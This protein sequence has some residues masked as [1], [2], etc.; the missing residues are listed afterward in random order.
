[1]TTPTAP[2]T[3]HLC[4]KAQS[5]DLLYRLQGTAEQQGG[6][7]ERADGGHPLEGEIGVEAEHERLLG[8][9]LPMVMTR[10]SGWRR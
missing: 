6:C 4:L 1:M 2:G 7:E 8:K 3:P 9:R 5:H 10:S